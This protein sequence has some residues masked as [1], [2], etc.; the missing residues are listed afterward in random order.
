MSQLTQSKSLYHQGLLYCA[1]LLMNVDGT[2]DE[3]ERKSLELICK[4]EHIPEQEFVSFQEAVKNKTER[5]VFMLGIDYLNCCSDQERLCAIVQL[6]RLAESDERIHRK[7][8]SLLM[9]SLKKVDVD[10]DDVEMTARLV[11]AKGSYS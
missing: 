8:L 9:Y 2:I 5:E 1:H 3:R 11:K 10:F 6:F 4:E 7:E